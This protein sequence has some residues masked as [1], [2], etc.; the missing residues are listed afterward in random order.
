MGPN[1]LANMINENAAGIAKAMGM[2]EI[3]TT[4]IDKELKNSE[5]NRVFKTKVFAI[6]DDVSAEEYSAFINYLLKNKKTTSVLREA[7]NWTKDGELIRVVDY[8]EDE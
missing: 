1:E 3:K 8:I 7:E 6:L 2:P 4:S 5:K